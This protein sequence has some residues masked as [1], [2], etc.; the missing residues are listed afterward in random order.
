[1]WTTSSD[2]TDCRKSGLVLTCYVDG[3]KRFRAVS[4]DDAE[5]RDAAA[6]ANAVQ[7]AQEQTQ[8]RAAR[9]KRH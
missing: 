7:E 1:M 6:I 3:R 5:D 2:Q 4:V 9:S 8:E